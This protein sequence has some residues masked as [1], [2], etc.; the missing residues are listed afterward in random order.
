MRGICPARRQRI[1]LPVGQP[2]QPLAARRQYPQEPVQEPVRF[3]R[4][5]FAARQRLQQLPSG[6]A[7]DERDMGI[8]RTL[9][10][11]LDR[12]LQ[13]AAAEG[14]LE[15]LA[16]RAAVPGHG[17]KQHLQ[18]VYDDQQALPG[19]A[20]VPRTVRSRR[21]VPDA[22]EQPF[23]RTEAGAEIGAALQLGFHQC[24]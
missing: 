6:A 1:G 7:G 16:E 23:A 3:A 17:R 19:R 9:E 22:P 4:L 20:G 8:G 2:R 11:P 12:G 5:V 15:Q 10:M 13:D 21:A 24:P 18:L 14:G